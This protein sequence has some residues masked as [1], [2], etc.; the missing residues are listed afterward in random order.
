[1]GLTLSL[2]L[3]SALLG[4]LAIAQSLDYSFESIPLVVVFAFAIGGIG[5]RISWSLAVRKAARELR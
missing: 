4:G 2:S 1:M 5:S 3:L